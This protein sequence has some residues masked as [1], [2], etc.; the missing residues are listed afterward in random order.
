MSSRGAE[1]TAASTRSRRE[2]KPVQLVNIAPDSPK[3]K[4]ARKPSSKAGAE[5]DANSAGPSTGDAAAKAGPAV[6]AKSGTPKVK[7]SD[8]A[9]AKA[10][11]RLDS[12]SPH[13][14]CIDCLQH[15]LYSSCCAVQSLLRCV[16]EQ[17]AAAQC[18]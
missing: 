16:F 2:A 7:S 6:K 15:M 8:A 18:I 10:A 13:V 17:E 4:P 12:V 1:K 11:T 5:T 3:R 14:E 9:S